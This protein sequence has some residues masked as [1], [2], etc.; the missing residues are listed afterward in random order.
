MN[1]L[2]NKLKILICIFLSIVLFLS[3]II[4]AITS[5][6]L[7]QQEDDLDKKI[8]ETNAHMLEGSRKVFKGDKVSQGQV[9]GTVGNTGK[10]TGT[11][12]HFEVLIKGSPVNPIPYLP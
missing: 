10:S 3:N 2:K 12:L 9:I 4:F 5:T 6:E 11:H 1:K 8:Q 7:K